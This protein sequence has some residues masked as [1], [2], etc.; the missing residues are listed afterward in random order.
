MVTLPNWKPVWRR[1]GYVGEWSEDNGKRVFRIEDG[2]ILNWC[3]VQGHTCMRSCTLRPSRCV[4]AFFI[5]GDCRDAV[6]MSVVEVCLEKC[7]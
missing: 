2:A 6:K 7:N 3:R 5:T 1:L 4:R